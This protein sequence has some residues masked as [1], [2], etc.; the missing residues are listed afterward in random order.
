MGSTFNRVQYDAQG[1]EIEDSPTLTSKLEES[2]EKAPASIVD[3]N[4]GN[5]A[6]KEASYQISG[7]AQIDENIREELR[8]NQEQVESTMSLMQT[9][10]AGGEEIPAETI[11]GM[12]RNMASIMAQYGRIGGEQND[13]ALVTF[14]LAV[15]AAAEKAW[16]S[17]ARVKLLRR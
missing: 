14:R 9:Q 12:V 3:V 13:E 16:K 1:N 10:I 17:N 5:A 7:G 2:I 8:A 4:A 15:E 11:K 6:L